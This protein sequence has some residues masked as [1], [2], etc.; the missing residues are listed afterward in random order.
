VVC[1]IL[2]RIAL[3]PAK[4]PDS[5]AQRFQ[6]L[7][8]FQ[9][10]GSTALMGLQ[11][12]HRHCLRGILGSGPIWKILL[13]KYPWIE[14]PLCLLAIVGPLYVI[15]CRFKYGKK[16]TKPGGT[17]VEPWG[18]GVRVIQL[19][20]IFILVPVIAILALEGILSGEGTGTL[21]GAIVGYALGGI[22]AAV[23]KRGT[24]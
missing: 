4:L 12:L 13:P 3:P 2:L 10:S 15:R 21:M 20:A 24:K 8:H 5:L 17:T 1:K 16:T 6:N 7:L 9:E 22:T 14:F 18:I 11:R 19:I 23:P